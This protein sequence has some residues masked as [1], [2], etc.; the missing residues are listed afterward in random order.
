MFP[1]RS[2]TYLSGRSSAGKVPPVSEAAVDI[3]LRR[4]LGLR[5]RFAMAAMCPQL[6]CQVAAFRAESTQQS[7]T[8]LSTGRSQMHLRAKSLA[9]AVC[10]IGLA[11]SAWLFRPSAASAQFNIPG[12]VF[13]GL[14][15]HYGS[16]AYRGHHRRVHESKRERRHKEAN[17]GAERGSGT[18]AKDVGGVPDNKTAVAVPDNKPAAA[19]LDSKK[20][21]EAVVTSAPAGTNAATANAAP[22]NP[23]ATNNDQ[24][25]FSPSR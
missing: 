17:D 22:A 13:G 16:G 2:V 24:P 23:A 10:A 20:P 6:H 25:S 5:R 21:A 7:M 3:C 11:V 18:D 8:G 14:N 9:V 12:I 4:R 19:A 15:Y 1:A